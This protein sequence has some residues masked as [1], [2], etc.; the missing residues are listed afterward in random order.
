M[1]AVG[2]EVWDMEVFRTE[3]LAEGGISYGTLS[4]AQGEAVFICGPSG[5]GK[6]TFLRLLNGTR[7]PLKTRKLFLSEKSS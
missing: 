1:Y 7:G 3:G 2:E 5:C 6:T 4:F